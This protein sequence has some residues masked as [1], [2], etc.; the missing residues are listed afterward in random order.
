MD[1][2]SN[3]RRRFGAGN[4]GREIEP[5]R[6]DLTDFGI[7]FSTCDLKLPEFCKPV[8][9]LGV[10]ENDSGRTAENGLMQGWEE[11]LWLRSQQQ[12]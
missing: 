8:N 10:A 7:F 1:E 12:W 2:V 9:H 5:H 4:Q 11:L 3:Q 6:A